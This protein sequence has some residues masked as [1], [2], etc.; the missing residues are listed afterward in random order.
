M[1]SLEELLRYLSRQRVVIEA[2]EVFAQR[3]SDLGERLIDGYVVDNEKEYIVENRVADTNKL[4]GVKHH[5]ERV[6]EGLLHL[7]SP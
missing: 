3:F 7:K 2:K 6:Q 1:D 4:V 5:P